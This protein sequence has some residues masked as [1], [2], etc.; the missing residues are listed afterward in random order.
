MAYFANSWV[1]IL[2]KEMGENW[3]H[4]KTTNIF[5]KFYNLGLKGRETISNEVSVLW[6]LN[7]YNAESRLKKLLICR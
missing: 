7:L 1:L 2:S 6:T 4:K 3:I 5:K